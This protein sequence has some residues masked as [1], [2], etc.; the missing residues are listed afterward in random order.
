MRGSWTGGWCRGDLG[1]RFPGEVPPWTV[2]LGGWVIQGMSAGSLAQDRS[3]LRPMVPSLW[4][5]SMAR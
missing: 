5:F 2:K 1:G 3:D 4:A